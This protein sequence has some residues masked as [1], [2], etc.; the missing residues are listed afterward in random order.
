[1]GF[2]KD[3]KEFAFKG[4]LVDMAV[5][6][7]IGTA[8]GAIVKSFIDNIVSPLIGALLKVPDLSQLQWAMG[9]SA[10][11]DPI[12]LKYGTF[13]QNLLDFL[14]MAFAVFV[15]IRVMAKFMRKAEEEAPDPG[16]SE[17]VKL[18]TEIRD[19]LAKG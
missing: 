7:V 15:A 9:E 18:L 3:F 2:L 5:G 6:I 10:N 14:I 16:P 19:S 8:A 4:N 11:G 13:L 17:E 12:F 1:M